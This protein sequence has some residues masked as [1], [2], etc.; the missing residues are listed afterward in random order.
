MFFTPVV[1]FM[2]G[3]I[4]F[5]ADVDAWVAEVVSNGGTVSPGR[6]VLVNTLVVGLKADGIWT[7]LDRLWL[8]AAENSQ[9]ALTDLKALTLATAVGGPTFTADS[10]YAGEDE[11]SPAKYILSNYD[12]SIDGVN[13]TQNSAHLA[14]WAVTESNPS[15]GGAAV[16]TSSGGVSQTNSFLPFVDGNYYFRLNDA[17]GYGPLGT[18]PADGLGLFL[19]NRS[20]ASANEVYRN[21]TLLESPNQNSTSLCEGDIMLLANNSF[22]GDVNIAERGFPNILGAASFGGSLNATEAG[23][24]YDLMRAYMTAVGVP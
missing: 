20:G 14:V 5:D 19:N 13:F 23:D 8:L 7:K 17:A 10:G 6:K 15:D 24:Y 16:G 3:E 21:G 11:L 22:F 12:A 18:P 1:P 4:V 2:G 9:S